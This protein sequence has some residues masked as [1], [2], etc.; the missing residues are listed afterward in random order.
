MKNF[1][2]LVLVIFALAT[3]VFAQK[4]IAV[5]GSNGATFHTNWASAWAATQTNDTIYLPGGTF[6]IG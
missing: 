3:G 2:L 6:N 4:T 1:L 5:Q